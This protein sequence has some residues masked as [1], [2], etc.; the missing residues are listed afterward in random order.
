MKKN[1]EATEERGSIVK[2]GETLSERGGGACENPVGLSMYDGPM[3]TAEY[4][5]VNIWCMLDWILSQNCKNTL[6][7]HTV[8]QLVRN[9]ENE[10]LLWLV[11]IKCVK[12]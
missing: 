12:I 10:M 8:D 1:G 4:I 11:G 6:C 7:F 2:C 3:E 9:P 5:W